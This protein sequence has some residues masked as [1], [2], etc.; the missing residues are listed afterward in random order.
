MTQAS[1]FEGEVLEPL[2]PE[3]APALVGAL[4]DLFAPDK[5]ARRR[6]LDRLRDLDA[7]RRSPLAAAALVQRL[8]EPDLSLRAEVVDLLAEVL[9][10]GEG[11]VRLPGEVRRWARA[12]LAEL[13]EPQVYA[14]LLVARAWPE[15]FPA[16]CRLLGACSFSGEIL[17]R[18]L[19]DR[20]TDPAVR[21]VAAR[22][23]GE[24]GYLDAM[25]EL[26]RLLL[27]QVSRQRRQLGMAFAPQLRE[28]EEALV[29]ALREAM[30]ALREAAG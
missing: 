27:R 8:V 22:A 1:L 10:A 29:P 6:A 30:E 15:R 28:E 17:L 4:Q 19:N 24:I 21:A 23:V 18:I 13:R 9:P 26:E 12:A 5:A 14:L 11:P 3:A 16:V 2:S 20:R 7:H 25:E